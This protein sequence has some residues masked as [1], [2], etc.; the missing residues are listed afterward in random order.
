M[1]KIFFGSSSNKP[2]YGSISSPSSLSTDSGEDEQVFEGLGVL[3][4][5]TTMDVDDFRAMFESCGVDVW[6]FIEMA[7]SVAAADYSAELKSRRDGIVERLYAGATLASA[8]GSSLNA[9]TVT[10]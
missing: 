8:S 5:M 6:T 9:E 10:T 4:S 7:I 2:A 1:D 3:F